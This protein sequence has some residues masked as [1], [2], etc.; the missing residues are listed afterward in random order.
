MAG[1][2]SYQIH[3]HR[4]HA[5]L[6]IGDRVQFSRGQYTHWAVYIGSDNVVHLVGE[7]RCTKY[8]NGDTAHTFTIG[9]HV[10]SQ[11]KISV[12]NFWD[13][14]E[15]GRASINNSRDESWSPLDQLAIVRKATFKI[16]RVEHSEVYSNCEHFA[17]WCRYGQ[18]KDAEFGDFLTGAAIAG[19]V[20]LAAGLAYAVSNWFKKEEP[21]SNVQNKNSQGRGRRK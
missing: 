14:L 16:G 7:G 21:A 12:D 15:G 3:N 4:V 18:W 11:A 10:Y 2:E 20:T 5:N 13:V 19:G 6:V 9:G 1:L 17:N 8:P